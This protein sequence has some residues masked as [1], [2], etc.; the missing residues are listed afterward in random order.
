[1]II[2]IIE[3]SPLNTNSNTNTSP[4]NRVMSESRHSV[5]QKTSVQPQASG[6]STLPHLD[7]TNPQREPDILTIKLHFFL[8]LNKTPKDAVPVLIRR[9]WEQTTLQY[10]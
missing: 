10:P 6:H 3:S 5:D 8:P 1:M 7:D 9:R 2:I 4:C